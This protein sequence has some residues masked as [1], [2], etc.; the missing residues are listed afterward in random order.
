M[1][2]ITP[3]IDM[4]GTTGEELSFDVQTN[5]DNG[6]ILSVL[7][8]TDFTGDPTTA[9]WSILDATIPSGPPSSFGSFAPVG[10]INISCLDGMVHFAF[11]YEGSDPTA[12]T[13]YHVDNIEI[14]GN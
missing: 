6:N 13:R 4:D 5:F 3:P 2:L 14:T 7:V 10:P 9:T 8:S 12:T 1:Y 11:F